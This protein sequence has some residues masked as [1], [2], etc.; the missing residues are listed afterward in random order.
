MNELTHDRKII[1]HFYELARELEKT[2]KGAKAPSLVL[3][4]SCSTEALL[5]LAKHV[6]PDTV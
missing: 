5:R 2:T 4:F 3:A 6:C 1:E